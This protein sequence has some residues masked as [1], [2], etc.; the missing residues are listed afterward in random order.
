MPIRPNRMQSGCAVLLL[1]AFLS[2]G[3]LGAGGL[4]VQRGIVAAPRF[5]ANLGVVS[6][7]A[8]KRVLLHGCEPLLDYSCLAAA[9]ASEIRTVYFVAL[10]FP[11]ELQPLGRRF[12]V[13]R[14]PLRN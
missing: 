5:A 11:P 8:E 1:A 14:V 4:L 2:C 7:A 13:V 12:Y 10:I 9:Q 6:V 3:L